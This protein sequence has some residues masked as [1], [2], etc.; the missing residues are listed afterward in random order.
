MYE[1]V[2][3]E[4]SSERVPAGFVGSR[5]SFFM[6]MMMRF[7]L[8]AA[9]MLASLGFARAE[10][11]P[12]AG[13]WAEAGAEDWKADPKLFGAPSCYNKFTEQLS[14]GRFRYYLVDHS[15]WRDGRKVEYLLAQEG[16]CTMNPD[17]RSEI[18]TG[19][20]MGEKES[21]WFIAYQG[22][23]SQGEVSGAVRATYY[24]NI[25]YFQKRFNGEPLVRIKCPFGIDAI[26]PYI[27]GRTIA[28]CTTRCRAFGRSETQ[29]LEE[30]VKHLQAGQ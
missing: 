25:F 21:T 9:A 28:D 5:R 17:G 15:K 1:T 16:T 18:C 19:K 10:E 23:A 14:D 30:L 24:E 22:D 11:H 27:T 2:R 29:E 20:V 13:L 12:Y 4:G 26:K 8:A 3:R 7:V 6:E